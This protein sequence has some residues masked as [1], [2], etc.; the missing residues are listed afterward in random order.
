MFTLPPGVDVR[1]LKMFLVPC[2]NCGGGH[3]TVNFQVD[4]L[5][6]AHASF[7][8]AEEAFMMYLLFQ[9][10]GGREQPD[11]LREVLDLNGEFFLNAYD[12]EE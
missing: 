11:F 4:N 3:G 7:D 1:Y 12:P 9:R 10:L 8:S 6:V 5:V 2:T